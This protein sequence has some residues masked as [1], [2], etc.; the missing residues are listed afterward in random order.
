MEEVVAAVAEAVEAAVVPQKVSHVVPGVGGPEAKIEEEE[1]FED[2]QLLHQQ[3]ILGGL[4]FGLRQVLQ[5]RL[6]QV[7]LQQQP[8][9]EGLVV[10]LRQV[11]LQV[12]QVL[13][14]QLEDLQTGPNGVDLV[15]S[16]L[17]ALKMKM[18]L[19]T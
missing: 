8:I 10:G 4:A 12:L 6:Q 17:K 16:P 18:Y 5:E 7:G 14:D 1:A 19:C 3:Q 2:L 11:L 15:G 9:L 13:P